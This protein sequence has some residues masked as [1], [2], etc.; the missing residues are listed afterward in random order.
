MADAGRPSARSA[1]G[2]WLPA[3]CWSPVG[4]RRHAAAADA[5][6]PCR[7]CRCGD[8]PQGPAPEIHLAL[9]HGVTAT[10]LKPVA[11][12]GGAARCAVGWVDR[13]WP[14][15]PIPTPRPFDATRRPVGA[16]RF[17]TDRSILALYSARCRRPFRILAVGAAAT[18]EAVCLDPPPLAPIRR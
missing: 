14:R 16:A 1:A 12:A 10:E 17:V 8:R 2:M 7:D 4:R 11:F 5:G 3:A 15:D 6:G 13:F 18:L 9:W